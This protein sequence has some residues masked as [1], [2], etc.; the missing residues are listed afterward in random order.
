MLTLRPVKSEA[1]LYR[2]PHKNNQVF[3]LICNPPHVI[4]GTPRSNYDIAEL[5]YGCFQATDT[6]RSASFKWGSPPWR[7]RIVQFPISPDIGVYVAADSSPN[8]APCLK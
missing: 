4:S 8:D 7:T 6:A 5:C 1:M 2:D 3:T